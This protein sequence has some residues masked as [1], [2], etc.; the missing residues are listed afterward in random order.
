MIALLFAALQGWTPLDAWR[1]LVVWLRGLGVGHVLH[2][3]AA[4]D[5]ALLETA[6][7]FLQRCVDL[8]GDLL[9]LVDCL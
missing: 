1:Q 4:R 8:S 7:E 9:A 2:L 3:G 6:M 5:I